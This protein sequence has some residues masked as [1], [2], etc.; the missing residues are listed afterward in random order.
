MPNKKASIKDL[1]QNHKRATHNAR[2]KRNVKFLT[3]QSKDLI[4]AGK[5]EEAK[6]SVIALQQ[7]MDKAAKV[8]VISRN[9][10]R[11]KKSSFMSSLTK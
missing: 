4:T 1:R 3:K 9:R 2:I 6:K 11:R 5:K 10:A 7:A 8:G